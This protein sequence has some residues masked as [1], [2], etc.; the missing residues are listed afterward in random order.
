[1]PPLYYKA[2]KDD[3]NVYIIVE[4]YDYIGRAISR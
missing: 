1:M 2:D 3:S 4:L